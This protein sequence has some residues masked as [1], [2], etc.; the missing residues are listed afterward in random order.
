MFKKRKSMCMMPGC[1]RKAVWGVTCYEDEECE[2]PVAGVPT[3][4]SC[5]AHKYD[6]NE[7]YSD[8][9]CDW[10]IMTPLFKFGWIDK[11]KFCWSIYKETMEE[12]EECENAY[13]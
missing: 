3:L 10:F 1:N 13:R 7:I 2:R 5:H 11:A 6:V 4:D 8:E 12:I 9:E